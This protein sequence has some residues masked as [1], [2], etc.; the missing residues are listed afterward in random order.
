MSH[1]L[2]LMGGESAEREVSLKTGYEVSKSLKNIGFKVTEF[3]PKEL[4]LSEIPNISPDIVFN[5]LHGR[6]GEDGFIQGLLEVYKIPYTHSGVLSSALAMDKFFSKKIFESAGIKC[7]SGGVYFLDDF[8]DNEVME[9]PYVIKP[10]NEG[11]SVGVNIIFNKEDRKNFITRSD[12]SFGKKIL[13]EKYVPGK[14]L[15]VAVF[16]DRAIGV[17]EIVYQSKVYDYNAKYQK[18]S[19]KHF[20]P[21]NISKDK[22]NEALDVGIKAHRSL[23]C[24]GITRADMRY[25]SI[26]GSE[27]IYLME[28]NTQPGLTPISLFPEI[29]SY[30]GIKF[31]EIIN[32][33][34][35]DAGCNK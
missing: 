21:A 2:V 27:E 19:S 16:K 10:I 4:Q 13:V 33:L 25:D 17:T 31:D 18:N 30:A 7:T 1:V 32:W 29:A 8:F 26:S 9:Y 28:L 35:E 15:T 24:R 6:F 20:I 22:Y 11:S 34:I 23:G 12:W 14:E 5:A 3:D